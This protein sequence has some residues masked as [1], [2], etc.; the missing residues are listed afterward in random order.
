MEITMNDDDQ[1]SKNAKIRLLQLPYSREAIELM[2]ITVCTMC[3]ISWLGRVIMV[4]LE[5]GAY[6]IDEV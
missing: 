4:G 6:R 1:Y 5:E 3:S 2:F